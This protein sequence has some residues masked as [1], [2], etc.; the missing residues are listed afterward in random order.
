MKHTTLA[1]WRKHSYTLGFPGPQTRAAVPPG[2]NVQSRQDGAQHQ[3]IFRPPKG[4]KR[5]KLPVEKGI[6]EKIGNL[7]L[8]WGE[9]NG[10]RATH[11]EDRGLLVVDESSF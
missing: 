4:K 3:F 1:P 7:I 2:W 5:N 6:T 11:R 9:S 8:W 10:N